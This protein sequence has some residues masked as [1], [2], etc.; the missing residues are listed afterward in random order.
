ML[1]S[2][3]HK[4]FLNKSRYGTVSLSFIIE[5][6][7]CPKCMFNNSKLHMLVLENENIFNTLHFTKRHI[8]QSL[9]NIKAI[10]IHF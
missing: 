5:S 8:R 4:Y 7:R 10:T 9:S 1:S 2:D 6:C 3:P